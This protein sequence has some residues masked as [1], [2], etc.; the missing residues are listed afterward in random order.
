MSQL[1][2]APGLEW[3]EARDAAQYPAVPRTAL[4]QRVIQCQT[5]TE[6]KLGSPHHGVCRQIPDP[7][8]QIPGGI[9]NGAVSHGTSSMCHTRQVPWARHDVTTPAAGAAASIQQVPTCSGMGSTTESSPHRPLRKLRHRPE[10]PQSQVAGVGSEPE[11]PQATHLTQTPH[12]SQALQMARG[13]AYPCCPESACQPQEARPDQ[14][15][16]QQRPSEV[17]DPEAGSTDGGWETGPQ[18]S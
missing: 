7:R 12:C 9:P 17:S 6:L 8:S 16:P 10:V 14:E 4:S 3:E 18:T 2:G 5:S 15:S 1:G 13:A 11:S